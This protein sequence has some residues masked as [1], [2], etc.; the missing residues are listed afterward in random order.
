MRGGWFHTGDL[1]RRDERGFYYFLG[2]M[3]DIIRR[4]GENVAAAEIEE[5]LRAHPKMMEVA[6]IA[7]PDELR[8]EEIK[9]YVLPVEG[10]IAARRS[11]RRSSCATA[12]SGWRAYKVPRYIE[13]RD[14]D[15]PRTPS[16]RV[17]KEALKAAGG[18]DGRQLGPGGAACRPALTAA[19]ALR[20][21][22]H[23]RARPDAR[24]SPHAS[25]RTAPWRSRG[26][27]IVAVGPEREVLADPPRAQRCSTP[28]AR[29]CIRA[30]SSRTTTPRCT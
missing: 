17:Q 11:R 5:V 27:D 18:P 3:K 16:L 12:P 28:T 25:T 26:R 7:V 15:F 23:E 14:T 19:A 4:S 9:A 22:G 8:G 29:S 20:P 24:R 6:V 30:S 10:D 1:A 21:A 13:Y 2:R